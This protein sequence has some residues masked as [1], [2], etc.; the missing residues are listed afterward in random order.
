MNN[1]IIKPTSQF[2]VI[3]HENKLPLKHKCK[4]PGIALALKAQ[5]NVAFTTS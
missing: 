5:S 4:W 2:E 1:V 3:P